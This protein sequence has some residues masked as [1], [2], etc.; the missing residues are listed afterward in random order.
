[1]ILA[2]GQDDPLCGSLITPRGSQSPHYSLR[3]RITLP[4]PA[5]PSRGI[6][7]GVLTQCPLKAAQHML[8]LPEHSSCGF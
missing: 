2:P 7:M 6:V 3:A 4:V 8:V 1:M 5:L